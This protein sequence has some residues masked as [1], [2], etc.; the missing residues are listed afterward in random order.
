MG[1]C[2][3]PEQVKSKGGTELLAR[4]LEARMP[5]ELMDNFQII[6]SRVRTVDPEKVRIF[7][8]H[9]LP[10]DPEADQALAN[11]AWSRWHRSVFVSNWQQQAYLGHY[12]IPWDRALVLQ[13]AVVPIQKVPAPDDKIRIIYSSTP[14]RGLHL[15]YPV[16][17]KLQEI[18]PN[19]ELVVFSSFKVYG[20]DERDQEFEPLFA[21]L[22]NDPA[23]KFTQGGDNDEVRAAVAQADIFA[24]PSIWMETSCLALMEAMTAGLIC[25]HPNYGALYETGANWTMMYQW[26]PDNQKHCAQLHAALGSAITACDEMRAGT[27]GGNALASRLN[28]QAQYASAFYGWEMRQAQWRALLEAIVGE[29]RT[30]KAP[31]DGMF[32]YRA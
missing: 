13:N 16:F 28:S 21:Q 19:I 15:L 22:R 1:I 14:H 9:D 6:P 18:H 29:D 20:W 5:K 7:W 17:K 2:F 8:A 11:G 32:V 26:T 3:T 30:I 24:Y 4:Q 23:V 31:D 25:I 27:Q 12:G 10:G